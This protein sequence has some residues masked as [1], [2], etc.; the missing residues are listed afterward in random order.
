[1][2][3]LLLPAVQLQQHPPYSQ[4]SG[5]NFAKVA[6]LLISATMSTSRHLALKRQGK[7]H[8]R[9]EATIDG[10]HCTGITIY[11][12][13]RIHLSVLTLQGRGCDGRW[14]YIHQVSVGRSEW[15]TIRA[16]K[17][18]T[19]TNMACWF[20]THTQHLGRMKMPECRTINLLSQ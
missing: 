1:M 12:W 3:Q 15:E 16:T 17:M 14:V 11:Y 9:V 8:S 10:A 5:K 7:R 4:G 18:K 13:D 20:G 2:L 19:T 6:A